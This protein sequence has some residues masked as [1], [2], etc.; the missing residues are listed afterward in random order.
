M[1]LFIV[2]D[3]HGCYFTFLELLQHWNP[4]R[5]MLIQVGDLVDRGNFSPETVAAAIALNLKHPKQTVFLKGN[6]EAGMLKYYGPQ[7]PYP[8]WLEW[9]GRETV[10]QYTVQ[11]HLQLPHLIWLA[12]RP[13]YWENDAVF[14]S[15]AG[16]ANTPTPL[17]EDDQDGVLWR[18]GPLRNIGRLQV[19][20]HTPTQDCRPAFDAAH[21]A[22]YLDTGA[23]MGNC[24]TGVKLTA[25]GEVLEYIAIDTH[26]T[27][28]S[29]R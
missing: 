17:D 21:Q 24:L 12:Q 10:E 6:H 18:R 13:L 8:N 2:G 29:F 27:D 25:A 28:I 3:V 14:V 1:N 20:G 5:E 4:A 9:G 16:L 23:Y 7:G 19:V 26:R 15:H 22:L 11:A